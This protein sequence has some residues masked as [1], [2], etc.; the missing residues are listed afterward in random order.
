MS[1]FIRT[2]TGDI[3]P[4]KLGVTQAHEHT[5][6]LSGPSS[7][8]NSALLLDSSEVAVQELS[9]FRSAGGS[10]LVDA[11]PIGIERSPDLMRRISER[12]GV[13]IIA[14]TG[15]HRDCFYP[16]NHFFR[17][18]TVDRLAKRLVDEI[19]NGMIDYSDG[20]QTEIKAGLVKFSSEYHHVPPLA[21]K[22][23]HAAA[24]AHLKTG[25]PIL[26]HTE[27]GTCGLEQVNIVQKHGVVP[28]SAILCHLD[29]NPDR[30]L[31]RDIAQ[32][33]AFLV[34]DGIGR[35]KYWPDSVII[36]LILE[37]L[38]AGFVDQLMLAMDC[39]TRSIWRHYGG[40][41]GLDYLLKSFVPRLRQVGVSENDV[42]KMLVGN[43][44][45]AFAFKTPKDP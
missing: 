33:G 8:I 5:I 29:R 45:R 25:V 28:S 14:T 6:I 30:Y 16:E 21:E 40:G 42:E 36:D 37:M 17:S 12:S 39:A 7:Q 13:R 27:F 24:I 26:T 3:V 41:P 38:Q 19:E 43:P 9:D 20:S 34:Y 18:E 32:T 1:D 10:A 2:V 31:H 15:F 4:D 23:A 11:Q 22:A 35:T 44:A